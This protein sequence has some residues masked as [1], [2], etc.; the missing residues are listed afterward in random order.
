MP[1]DRNPLLSIPSQHWRPTFTDNGF[2]VIVPTGEDEFVT[3]CVAGVIPEDITNNVFQRIGGG[4]VNTMKWTVVVRNAP[5]LTDGD[6]IVVTTGKYAGKY[7]AQVVEV[8]PNEATMI[9]QSIKE[10]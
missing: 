2:G 8:I 6:A 3:A 1:I 10:S 4:V 9:A 7:R 5:T